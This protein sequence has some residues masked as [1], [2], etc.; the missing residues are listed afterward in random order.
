[1]SMS[2]SNQI[3]GRPQW[4]DPTAF[5]NRVVAKGDS[6][7]DGQL[8]QAEFTTLRQN[9]PGGNNGSA[10]AASDAASLFQQIDTDGNG[11]ASKSELSAFDQKLMD[12]LKS[13]LLQLQELH[14]GGSS[15][16]TDAGDGTQAASGASGQAGGASPVDQLFASLD[17]NKDGSISADEFKAALQQ[18]DGGQSA[19]GA[20]GH[21]HH[22]HGAPPPASADSGGAAPTS[23]GIPGV[24]GSTDV[25]GTGETADA[26]VPQ[27]SDVDLQQL[28]AAITAYQNN[29]ASSADLTKT[30]LGAVG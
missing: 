2:T 13:A 22:H 12:N 19:Q 15:Q 24:G 21:H 5:A 14:G 27:T 29:P 4:P 17:T 9:V 11:Q 23:T 7:G 10:G 30:L 6:D 18:H 26:S 28:M 8:S 1:M 20:H 3:G 16:G 25:T